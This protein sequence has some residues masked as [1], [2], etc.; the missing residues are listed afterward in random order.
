MRMETS[1]LMLLPAGQRLNRLERRGYLELTNE[2]LR[3]LK[4]FNQ[5]ADVAAKLRRE[6]AT[7]LVLDCIDHF[8][9]SAAEVDRFVRADKMSDRPARHGVLAPDVP[10][11][12][13]PRDAQQGSPIVDATLERLP[14]AALRNRSHVDRADLA[15]NIRNRQD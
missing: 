8:R 12:F 3:I 9:W 13:M 10:L 11:G 1:V 6:P 15:S 2:P 5:F 4:A 7:A 14:R